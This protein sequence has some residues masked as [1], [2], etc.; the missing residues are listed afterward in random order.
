MGFFGKLFKKGDDQ[1]DLEKFANGLT[2][3]SMNRHIKTLSDP[4]KV[5]TAQAMAV[6][7]Y[8]RIFANGLRDSARE[9]PGGLKNKWPLPYDKIIAEAAAFYYFVLIKDYLPKPNDDGE[10]DG[11]EDA[12]DKPNDPYFDTLRTSLHV[13]SDLVHSLSGGTIPKQFV[14]NRALAFSSIQRSKT[15]NLVEELYGFIMKAWNPND[16]GRPVL[17]ISAPMIPI[18]ISI[19][20]M[21]IDSVIAACRELFDEKARNPNAF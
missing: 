10:W 8:C 18:Q 3:A 11:D 5:P 9:M 4:I 13:C 15:K 21:P 12:E 1:T 6:L 14:V 2:A 16:D 19:V 20:S 17:D 7:V